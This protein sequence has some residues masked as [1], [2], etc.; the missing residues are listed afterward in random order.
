MIGIEVTLIATVYIAFSVLAQRKLVNRKRMYEV[1]SSLKAKSNELTEMS[2]R[3]ADKESMA[4]K[5]KEITSL[6]SES[7]S[8]QFKPM[9]AILPVFFLLYYLAL[10]S[11]FPASATVTLF[12]MTFNYKSYFIMVAFVLG[13]VVSM[14]VMAYDSFKMKRAA[15]ATVKKGL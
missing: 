13:F 15:A 10:P 2:K 1:Q 3:G 7:M 12:S 5:Q 9:L 4:A 11:L 6:L 8:S 14:A